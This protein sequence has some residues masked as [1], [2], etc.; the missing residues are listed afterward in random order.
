MSNTVRCPQC[1]SFSSTTKRCSECGAVF[2]RRWAWTTLAALLVPVLAFAAWW[3]YRS[4]PGSA[5]REPILDSRPPS[6]VVPATDPPAAP[7]KSPTPG[8]AEPSTPA[9]RPASPVARPAPTRF[10]ELQRRLRLILAQDA[11][12]FV[13]GQAYAYPLPGTETLIVPWQ[14]MNGAEQLRI[15]GQVEQVQQQVLAFEPGRFAIVSD[16]SP[17]A[18]SAQDLATDAA[19]LVPGTSLFELTDPGAAS[20]VR[21]AGTVVEWDADQQAI[22]LATSANLAGRFVFAEDGRLVGVGEQSAKGPGLIIA[23]SRVQDLATAGRMTSLSVLQQWFENDV[24]ARIELATRY[25]SA[26]HW[27]RAA[28]LYFEALRLDPFVEDRI[29]LPL[30]SALNELMLEARQDPVAMAQLRL[31]VEEAVQRL[32]R[33]SQALELLGLAQLAQKEHAAAIRSFEQALGLAAHE[34]QAAIVANIQAVYLELIELARKDGRLQVAIDFAHEGLQR[35]GT[36]LLLL[37]SLGYSYYESGDAAN[38]LHYLQQ[39]AAMDRGQATALQPLLDRLGEQA[40]N[41]GATEIRFDPQA[42]VIR[43]IAQ[44]NHQQEATVLVDTGATLTAI[45]EQLADQLGISYRGP[46][47]RIDVV[48]ANGRVRAPVVTLSHI[49]LQGAAQSNVDAV[50][51]P[52][53]Q[54]ALIGLN[55]LQ[56]FEVGIDSSRGI[57][58]LSPQR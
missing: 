3:G 32:P 40:A 2:Q 8:D 55:F 43:T 27:Q 47:R 36:D 16:P 35:Y 22:R 18:L 49:N 50:V 7:P 37:K 4:L 45:S 11:T 31:R 23:A 1:F 26:A 19:S 29:E 52:L 33:N 5:G 51:L 20:P 10:P 57:L 21:H 12:E 24:Q 15:A 28:D 41:I 9:Q 25:A 38:A 30:L 53:P 14:V 34:T 13:T 58:R 48:T 42:G 56:A 17:S 46:G 39:V 54:A 44:F 6:T